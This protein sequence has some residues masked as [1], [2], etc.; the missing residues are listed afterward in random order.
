MLERLICFYEVKRGA[1]SKKG[2]EKKRKGLHDVNSRIIGSGISV[3]IHAGL[4]GLSS[5]SN[6]LN[7]LWCPISMEFK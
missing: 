3:G 5:A 2:K 4:I 6:T 1:E 7:I